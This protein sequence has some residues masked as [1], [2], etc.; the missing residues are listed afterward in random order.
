MIYRCSDMT[1]HIWLEQL[2][3]WDCVNRINS[4]ARSFTH[5]C[6]ICDALLFPLST[7]TK[8]F[9]LAFQIL[10]RLSLFANSF[11]WDGSFTIIA[12]YHNNA[13]TK[14]KRNAVRCLSCIYTKKPTSQEFARK[15]NNKIENDS[16]PRHRV[17]DG[18]ECSHTSQRCCFIFNNS[19]SHTVKYRVQKSTLCD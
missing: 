6:V 7:S 11:G 19:V 13:A 18:I 4:S 5:I 1:S 12:V 17:Y 2:W 10:H 16:H 15:S 14:K 9:L 3:A 8:N